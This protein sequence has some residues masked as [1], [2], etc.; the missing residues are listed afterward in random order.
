VSIFRIKT[1]LA[2]RAA[3]IVF[4]QEMR[5]S[6]QTVKKTLISR[7]RAKMREDRGDEKRNVKGV[8]TGSG[9]RLR[10]EV[11]GD[12]PQ[13]IVDERGRRPGVRREKLAKFK[14]KKGKEFSRRIVYYSGM[15]PTGAGSP[16]RRWAKKRGYKSLFALA[17]KIA[18]DGIKPNKPF[19]RTEKESLKD[20]LAEFNSALARGTARLNK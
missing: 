5:S 11:Y 19:E 2:T 13:T 1:Q 10:L 17:M 12:Q 8:V 3:E 16:L 6:L 15:P 20:V 9:F 7:I 4:A 18:R 14:S